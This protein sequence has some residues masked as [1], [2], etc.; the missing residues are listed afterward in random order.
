MKTG[1]QMILEILFDLELK[2]LIRSEARRSGG[3]LDYSLILSF[4][5]H[6]DYGEH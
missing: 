4:Q 5:Y 3:R 2:D 1:C 6:G